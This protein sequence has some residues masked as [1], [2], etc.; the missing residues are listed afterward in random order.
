MLEKRIQQSMRLD[1]RPRR[2]DC[3]LNRSRGE[4]QEPSGWAEADADIPQTGASTVGRRQR[5]GVQY[6]ESAAAHAIRASEIVR[7]AQNTWKNE[8]YIDAMKKI[9]L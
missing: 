5:L 8:G 3:G 6:L 2:L 1:P 9:S 4:R 7:L